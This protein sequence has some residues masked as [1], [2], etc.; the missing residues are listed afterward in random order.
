MRA[1][2]PPHHH[3]LLSILM[4]YLRSFKKSEWSNYG[5]GIQNGA[6]WTFYMWFK[7]CSYIKTWIFSEMYQT[8]G[9]QQPFSK[10]YNST[11]LVLKYSPH[12]IIITEPNK[13]LLNKHLHFLPVPILL[14]DSLCN[15]V[16]FCLY[17]SFPFCRLAE[18]NSSASCPNKE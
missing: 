6:R 3:L 1:Y 13:S 4:T 5:S 11:N 12:H 15:L 9:H 16:G 14:P 17:K 8:Q 2:T 18:H 7:T 10:H